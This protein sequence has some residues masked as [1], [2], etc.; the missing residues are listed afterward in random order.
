M[1]SKFD[2]QFPHIITNICDNFCD[3]YVF[4]RTKVVRLDVKS[5]SYARNVCF[6]LLVC[7]IHNYKNSFSCKPIFSE[8]SSYA[9]VTSYN[10]FKLPVYLPYSTPTAAGLYHHYG[11]QYYT[12]NIIRKDFNVQQEKCRTKNGTLRNS[13]INWIVL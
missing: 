10:S 9:V 8:T 12:G 13:N 7:K 6:F 2:F 1:K 5:R 3:K 11:Q 4:S